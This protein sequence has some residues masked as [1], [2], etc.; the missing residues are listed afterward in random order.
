MSFFVLYLTYCFLN[1]AINY[2]LYKVLNN[3]TY[4]F[5]NLFTILEYLFIILFYRMIL[6]KKIYKKVLE[7]VSIIFIGYYLWDLIYFED[8]TIDFASRPAAIESIILLTF[9]ILYL[10]EQIND[11]FT[12]FIYS[13]K[14]FWIVVAIIIYLSGTFF[15]F[16]FAQKNMND[17]V[18]AE[19]Y[20]VMNSILYIIKNLIISIAFL[21]PLPDNRDYG[22]PN[23][24][25]SYN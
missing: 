3:E 21:I 24:I 2:Y 18:F 19:Q 4:L 1:E 20:T 8:F 23:Y 10:F 9:S 17:D 25:N 15:L 12:I 5:I 22:N 14:S 7:V 11:T 13:K 6:Q 16:I